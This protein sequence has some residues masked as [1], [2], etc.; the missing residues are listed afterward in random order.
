MTVAGQQGK[1][2]ELR[3][4]DIRVPEY[5]RQADWPR[6]NRYAKNFDWYLFGVLY[7][8]YRQPDYYVVDGRH[9]LEAA[10]QL[11]EVDMLPCMAFNFMGPEH[12]AEIFVKLQRFRKPLVTKD[13]HSAEL[14]AGGDFGAIARAAETLVEGLAFETVPL[15]TIR[16]LVAT[17]PAA[18]SRVAEL[19][20]A[21]S[22]PIPL[23]KDFIEALVYLEDAMGDLAEKYADRILDLGYDRL[24]EMMRLYHQREHAE[25]R[26]GKVASPR[27]KAEALRWAI[28]EGGYELRPIEHD[29]ETIGA[30]VV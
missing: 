7:V 14:L 15:A 22:G 21:L 13:I 25:G 23:H 17:K 19:V 4:A 8:S 28:F 9:R 5:Q 3:K 6:I 20:S 18:L 2:V 11:P 26:I 27:L 29:G 24:N 1:L 12:E 30:R 10:Q 16:K